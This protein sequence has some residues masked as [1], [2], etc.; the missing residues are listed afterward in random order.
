MK[1]KCLIALAILLLFTTPVNAGWFGGGSSVYPAGGT[2]KCIP[3]W[4]GSTA[5]CAS[6]L[7]LGDLNLSSLILNSQ[8]TAANTPEACCTGAGTGTCGVFLPVGTQTAPTAEGQFY[9]NSTTDASTIG[10]G[11]SADEL[12]K[13]GV[14]EITVTEFIPIAYAEDGGTAPDAAAVLSSTGKIRYR[15]FS[16]S[17]DQDVRINWV[18]PLNYYSGLKFR[19]LGYVSASTAP[20]DT[21][22]VALSL[23]GC[24]IGNSDALGCTVGTPQTSSLTISG[25]GYAQYDRLAGAFSSA[26]TVTDI[27]AG[28]DVQFALIRLATSTDTYGQKFGVS[29]IELKYKVKLGKSSDY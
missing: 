18:V 23:A 17:V 7:N 13:P 27:A 28:E 6:T 19:F 11:S 26:I 2:T 22:V 21:E 3:Y 15:D 8:C 1:N 25:S 12:L 5:S 9:H 4:N 14:T 20:A 10:N 29:G 16:G 24:S